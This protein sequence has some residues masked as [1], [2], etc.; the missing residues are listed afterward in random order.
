MI[1]N[2]QSSIRML[3]FL[4]GRPAFAL[5]DAHENPD[6]PQDAPAVLADAQTE[7]FFST[8]FDPQTGHGG[9]CVETIETNSSYSMQQSTHLYS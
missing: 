6:L 4:W 5:H 7:N 3:Q 8:F 9:F 1:F 2:P